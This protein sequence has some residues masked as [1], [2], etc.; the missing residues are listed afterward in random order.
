MSYKEYS[1][2]IDGRAFMHESQSGVEVFTAQLT[3]NIQAL[4]PNTKI[5]K[6][7]TKNRYLQH[8]WE[9]IELPIAAKNYDILY[10]PAN[11]API[12]SFK[13]TKIVVTLHDVAYLSHPK[14]VS[15]F[16]YLYYKNA[17]P[18]ILKKAS[19]VVTIS[20]SSRD[21]ILKYYP[22]AKKKL[23][24]IYNGISEYFFEETEVKK[25]N[26]ILYVGS[27]NERKNFPAVI[28][29]FKKIPKSYGY[30]L[31]MVGNFSQNFFID[32]KTR[33]VLEKIKNDKDILLKSNLSIKE[34]RALY[35]K[36]KV[37]IYPSFYEGFGFPLLEAMASKTPVITSNISSMPEICAK[38]AL[39]VDPYDQEDIAKKLL[40]LI[41]NENLQKE[42]I[43]KGYKRASLF[44]WE[45]TAKN[46]LKLFEEVLNDK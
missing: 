43:E 32:E 42:L 1:I 35:Q 29:A 21:E 17:M 15:K 36:A 9:H 39:Y 46:Y 18:L 22:F 16:F 44:K 30:K 28:K 7:K 23:E 13:N 25:E 3:E 10:S 19:K 8:I 4:H 12:W 31:V 26:I 14:T 38:S 27:L 24:V 41:E 40:L 6:P 45:K 11:I 34:L 37:F 5:E 2:L 20:E 33:A